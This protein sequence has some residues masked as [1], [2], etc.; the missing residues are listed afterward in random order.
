MTLPKIVEAPDIS[1]P[2]ILGEPH[3]CSYLP[4]R[5]ARELIVLGL[6]TDPDTVAYLLERGF[7]RSGNLFYR[8]GCRDCAACVPIRVPVRDFTPSRSQRRVLRRNADLT[9]V[10]AEPSA[11]DE[12]WDLFL[13]YQHHQHGG[14]MIRERDQFEASFGPA[15]IVSLELDFRL[16]G[17]LVGSGLVDVSPDGLSSVYFYFDPAEARRSLGVFS[18]LCEIEHCR[19]L[20]LP[21]WYL[22]YWIAG[23]RKMEYK[24]RFR[25]CELRDADG[26]WRLVRAAETP[27]V[28]K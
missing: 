18:A 24:T 25:P 2:L 16:A 3:P 9:V 15:S 26:D 28:P 13:R 14:Q 6:V 20:G 5:S 10:A 1:G 22:G 21:H 8:P 19:R 17:R 4:N 7:R 27:P 11:D 12:H 23:C